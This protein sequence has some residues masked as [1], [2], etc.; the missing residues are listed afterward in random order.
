M[1]SDLN[2]VDFANVQVNVLAIFS[3]L[4]QKYAC[5]VS[6]IRLS[7]MRVQ[8]EQASWVCQCDE[9]VVQR[10]EQDFKVTLQQQS[11]LDQW[12]TWLDNVVTQ[13]LKP[14][15]GSRSFPKAARQFLLKWSFYR[16]AK[17]QIAASLWCL[18]ERAA[19]YF[20]HFTVPWWSGT[21]PCAAPPASVPSTWFACCTT[22]TCFTW[23]NIAW[24]RL[25]E[26]RPL[27][28][29]GRC[30]WRLLYPILSFRLE[31]PGQSDDHWNGSFK[32]L[33]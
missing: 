4:L 6:L 32:S 24:L 31:S 15:Q 10:L 16:S 29:W 8:Q 5:R 19:P 12:A 2:R 22:S 3:T 33:N 17:A 27:A 30:V 20:F 18:R 7:R 14:H 1:L 23:W 26:R 13:V 28:S 25:L 11:S 9:S 21:W